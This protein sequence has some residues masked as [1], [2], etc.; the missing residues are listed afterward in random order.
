TAPSL[1]LAKNLFHAIAGAPFSGT[2][3][4]EGGA[5]PLLFQ[6]EPGFS[7]VPPG[8]TFNSSG[9][10]AGTPTAGGHFSFVARATDSGSIRQSVTQR[11]RV[12]VASVDQRQTDESVP[13]LELGTTVDTILGQV[14]TAGVTGTL[15]H[16]A[17]PLYCSPGG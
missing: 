16:I 13:D 6:V 4:A 8:L 14:V 3:A 12:N 17:F 10:V 11:I 1:R 2:Q 15:A 5:A 7:A 9:I